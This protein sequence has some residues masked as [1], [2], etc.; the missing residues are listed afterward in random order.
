MPG[1]AAGAAPARR[2]GRRCARGVDDDQPAARPRCSARCRDERR[3]RLGG[4]ARRPAGRRRRRPR[5]VERERQA[6]VE[7]EGADAGGGR[8]RH[9]EPAVVV[10][11]RGCRRATRANL[12]SGR[13]SRWSARRRR[14]P[15]PRRARAVADAARAGRRRGR[16]PRPRSPA[17]SSPS[18][19]RTSGVV[20]R[21]RVVEQ[22]GARSSPSGTGRRG[23]SG[24]RARPTVAPSPRRRRGAASCRT[25]A[26]STGSGVCVVTSVPPARPALR[27][28]SAACPARR[29][30]R[31]GRRSRA[32]THGRR[33]TKTTKAAER[34]SPSADPWSSTN[35]ERRG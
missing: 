34:A 22:L 32:G 14:R 13:P 5:S 6:A 33:R 10:D 27:P 1:A 7:P 3:H 35:A 28:G 26:R 17:R 11:V 19:S 25:A 20:S 8:R 23:W 16:A 21:S 18:A 2:G 30:D 15:R 9:A 4:V 12:P 31:A 29:S 24:S